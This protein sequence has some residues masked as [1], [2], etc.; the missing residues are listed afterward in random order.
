MNK[1]LP[2]IAAVLLAALIE[3]PAAPAAPNK[4]LYQSAPFLAQGQNVPELLL[5]LSKDHNIFTQ[6][7][8]NLVDLNGDGIIDNGF[9][10]ALTYIGYFDAGSCYKY[11]N[12]RF[13]RSG[14]ADLQHPEAVRPIRPA[15]LSRRTDIPVPPSAHGICPDASPTGGGV[16][17]GNWL[18][19]AVTS[20]MDAIRK[21][22]Y[23]G[24]RSTDTARETVLEASYVPND[25]HVWGVEA[26][27]DN[28]WAEKMPT[29]PYYNLGHF[30]AFTKPADGNLTFFARVSSGAPGFNPPFLS[31]VYNVRAGHTLSVPS[32]GFPVR[33]WDWTTGEKV[34]LYYPALPW[35]CSNT[36]P[37]SSACRTL[38][39]NA[40]VKVCEAGLDPDTAARTG[41]LDYS[42]GSSKPTGLL[43]KY[44]ANNKMR[45]GLLTGISDN[46]Y[47]K[48]GGAL[49]HYI[50]TLGEIIDLGTGQVKPN[51]LIGTI[52]DLRITGWGLGRW[53]G[54][55][56][57]EGDYNNDHTA[58]GNP[59]GEM[60]YEAVR[61]FARADRN[62]HGGG[63]ARDDFGPL[64]RSWKNERPADQDNPCERPVI[65]L[66]SDVYPSYDGDTWQDSDPRAIN[67]AKT[68]SNIKAP[69]AVL[70]NNFNMS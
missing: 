21:V 4:D 56:W 46:S 64:L 34:Q 49:R 18:N 2:V 69:P 37:S 48:E 6:A 61:H 1:S 43:Q 59:L 54:F 41:C 26:A 67:R 23:G 57:V 40:R 45:F 12:D 44:G 19:Y 62:F 66:L 11:R 70:T 29:A 7:Y 16:W 38:N 52:D 25:A 28:L 13:E 58:W 31:V 36:S 55:K 32:F 22:L 65:M 33:L 9:N 68:L 8:N 20:R 30:T 17:H 24:K 47:R 15:A 39:L 10:P 51:T 27:A 50:R 5:V 63:I 35:G 60:L 53:N 3:V 42:N 14:P